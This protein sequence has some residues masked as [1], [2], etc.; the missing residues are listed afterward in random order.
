[1]NLEQPYEPKHANRNVVEYR[2]KNHN[3][4]CVSSLQNG[5]PSCSPAQYTRNNAKHRNDDDVAAVIKA[6]HRATY[7]DEMWP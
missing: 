6:L 5:C 7:D 2:F 4:K 1:M 3:A